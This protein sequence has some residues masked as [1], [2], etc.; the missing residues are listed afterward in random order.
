MIAN[1]PV[2]RSGFSLVEVLVATTLLTIVMMGLA[3]AAGV[4]LSQMGKARQDLLYAADVQQVAD[5]LVAV[6][7]NNVTSGSTSIRGRPVS[8]T[9]AT[10][11]PNSQQVTLIVQRRGQQDASNLYS[12]TVALF[13]AKPQVQ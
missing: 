4:G 13:L 3:G 10:V 8:W 1:R 7:W 6:G 12:D 2:P 11:G 9:A 5:S